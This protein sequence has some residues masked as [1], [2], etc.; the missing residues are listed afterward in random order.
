MGWQ[1]DAVLLLPAGMVL[2]LSSSTANS[3]YL[4]WLREI[5]RSIGMRNPVASVF[6]AFLLVSLIEVPVAADESYKDSQAYQD[7]LLLPDEYKTP[8]MEAKFKF[9]F[10][11]ENAVK[12]LPCKFGSTVSE[13]LDTMAINKGYDDLGW[14][15]SGDLERLFVERVFVTWNAKSITY[16]WSVDAG[17]QVRAENK[18]AREISGK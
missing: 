16:R 8:E 3:V 12:S 5:L 17:G 2:S 13:C 11:A 10:D 1:G 18:E 7:Y 6:Y 9:G 15:T 4:A 14:T